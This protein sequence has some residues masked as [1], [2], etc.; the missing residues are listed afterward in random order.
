MRLLGEA[1][2]GG[3]GRTGGGGGE[4]AKGTAATCRS[5]WG[6]RGS[7]APPQGTGGL[8]LGRGGLVEAAEQADL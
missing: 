2:W 4:L 1:S 7:Q 6:H 3:F 5:P 8:G